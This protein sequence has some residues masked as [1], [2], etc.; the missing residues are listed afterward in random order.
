MPELTQDDINKIRETHI[1]V[2]RMDERLGENGTGL[3]GQVAH[4]S[5][6]LRKLELVIAFAA[7]GGGITGGIIGISKLLGG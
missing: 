4:N 2:A 1:L 5:G 7:G 6:R 3:C